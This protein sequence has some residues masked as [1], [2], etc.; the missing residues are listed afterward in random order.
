[1]RTIVYNDTGDAQRRLDVRKGLS[2]RIRVCKITLDMELV[3]SLVAFGLCPRG[4]SYLIA[5]GCE[6]SCYTRTDSW[7]GTKNK[8]DWGCGRHGTTRGRKIKIF[9]QLEVQETKKQLAL[10]TTGEL[11]KSQLYKEK[12]RKQTEEKRE[13]KA[14]IPVRRQLRL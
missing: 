6:G 5:F 4:Q 14:R 10:F 11:K 9:S 8:D 12:V 13:L 2:H 7:A 3:R 1:M